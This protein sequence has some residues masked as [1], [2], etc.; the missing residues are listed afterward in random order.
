MIYGI[1]DEYNDDN[2]SD[3]EDNSNEH[4]DGLA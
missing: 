1:G 3:R 2:D 4:D